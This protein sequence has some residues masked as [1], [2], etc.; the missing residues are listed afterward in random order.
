MSDGE[1]KSNRLGS[2]KQPKS[3]GKGREK[4]VM[5][6]VDSDAEEDNDGEV[7]SGYDDDYYDNRSQ[8]R[9][10]RLEANPIHDTG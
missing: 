3:N 1:Q 6:Y 5:E 9:F 2:K 10:Y 4:N 8:K 7:E